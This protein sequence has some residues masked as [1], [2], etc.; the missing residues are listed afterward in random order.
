MKHREQKRLAKEEAKRV[1]MED[2]SSSDEVSVDLSWLPDPDKIYGKQEN[3]DSEDELYDHNFGSQFSS[4]SNPQS[5]ESEID[6]ESSN[7]HR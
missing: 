5:E 4:E 6:D 1:K 3:N 2:A 7:I